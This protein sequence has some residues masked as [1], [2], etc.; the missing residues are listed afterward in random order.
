MKI[1]KEDLEFIAEK[2]I[3]ENKLQEQLE[4][5]REGFPYLKLEGPA[6]LGHGISHLKPEMEIGA[7]T[8]L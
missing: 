2:G 6:T 1:E 7:I 4:M 8:C 5:L 3:T